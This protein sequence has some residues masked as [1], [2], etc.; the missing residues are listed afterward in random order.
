MI[1]IN[2]DCRYTKIIGFDD[3]YITENG[4]V[5]SM[6]LRG[7]E[8]EP[9]LRKL[10]PKDP[11]NKNKYLNIVLCTDGKQVTKSIHRL[12][13]EHFVEGYFD[14]AV[15]NHKDGNNRNNQYTNLEWISQKENIHKSYITSNVDQTRNCFWW[16]LVDKAGNPIGRFKGHA[17]LEKFVKSSGINASATSLTK[18]GNSNGY[19]V[20][21]TRQ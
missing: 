7:N 12:V 21:K 1:K 8:K 6:R 4:D 14:G 2:I 11:N 13:A 3:Y 10:K 20:I 5:Y 15:V 16:N 9:R 18:Y 17:E 19:S